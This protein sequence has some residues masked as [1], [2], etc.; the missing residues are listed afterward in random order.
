[1]A[2]SKELIDKRNQSI[3]QRFNA[4]QAEHPQW[5]YD[6]LLAQMEGEFYLSKRTLAAII[7]GEAIYK[8]A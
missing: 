6:A 5:R 1:M 2:R 4:L 8:T 3:K 7:N